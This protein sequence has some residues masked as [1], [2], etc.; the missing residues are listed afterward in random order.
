MWG[1]DDSKTLIWNVNVSYAVYP[2]IK[3]NT[4]V[5][6]SMGH[7]IL[8]SMLCKQKLVPKS[9]T[10]AELVGV[11]DAMMFVMWAL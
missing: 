6:L 10:E 9:F 11:D 8:M 5:S 7:E 3:S 1:A 2:Y 4:S